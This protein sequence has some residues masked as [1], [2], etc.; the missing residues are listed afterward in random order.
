MT[1]HANSAN[2][3]YTTHGCGSSKQDRS[4]GWPSKQDYQEIPCS[5]SETGTQPARGSGTL[6]QIHRALDD[7]AVRD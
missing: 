3:S 6:I 1:D 4:S 7:V 2:N 5:T